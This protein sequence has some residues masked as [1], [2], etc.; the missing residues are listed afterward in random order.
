MSKKIWP[1]LLLPCLLLTLAFAPARVQDQAQVLTKATRQMVAEEDARWERSHQQPQL[2][3]HTQRG[4][5][6]HDPQPLTGNRVYL[7]V[8]VAGKKANVRLVTSSKMRKWLKPEQ[9]NNLVLSQAKKLQPQKRKQFNL[10]L[11]KI[12][13]ALVT[14]IEQHYGYVQDKNS[15]NQIELTQ[16]VHPHKQ[17]LPKAIIVGLVVVF[18]MF[19]LRRKTDRRGLFDR[20]MDKN[21]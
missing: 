1:W 11:Q 7:L 14:L 8:G 4:L 5:K 19:W 20:K 3:V 9:T 15:L 18:A 16:M 2:F 21:K 6:F 17:N 10:A 12:I 13:Q